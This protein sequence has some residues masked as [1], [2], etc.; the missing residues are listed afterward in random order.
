MVSEGGR[1]IVMRAPFV[2]WKLSVWEFLNRGGRGGRDDRGGREGYGFPSENQS[3]IAGSAGGL[4]RTGSAGNVSLK[5]QFPSHRLRRSSPGGRAF[6]IRG[7]GLWRYFCYLRNFRL[8]RWN[9]PSVCFADSSPNL[10]NGT[11]L[12]IYS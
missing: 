2:F 10:G 8:A 11:H 5:V 9:N 7:C 4:W 6:P 3:Y 12:R 1:L